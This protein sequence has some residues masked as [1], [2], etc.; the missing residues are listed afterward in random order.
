MFTSYT[1]GPIIYIGRCLIVLFWGSGWGKGWC[2]LKYRADAD[3][4]ADCKE[5][6]CHCADHP[7]QDS[8]KVRKCEVNEV[9]ERY[10]LDCNFLPLDSAM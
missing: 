10:H 5:G 7:G 1:A 9:C 3:A 8:L 4:D 6:G 2:V